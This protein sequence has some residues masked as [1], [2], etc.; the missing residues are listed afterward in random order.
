MKNIL[1]LILSTICFFGFGQTRFE[2]Y[3]Y[4]PCSKEVK[5]IKFFGLKKEG[6]ALSRQ[7][8]SGIL[9]LR[10][11]GV[12]VLSYVIDDIDSTQLGKKYHIKS[13][14]NFSDTLRLLSIKQCLEPI[15]HPNFVGYCCC[16]EK[17]EGKQVDY[18]QNGFKRIEGNFKKGKPVGELI[19]Y[20]PNGEI[21]EVHKYNKKSK[22]VK[23]SK[24][25]DNLF[26]KE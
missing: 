3:S 20:H 7:D 8:T 2:L 17:C 6:I 18:Y 4:D 9:L 21:S 14:K 1:T 24:P 25:K 23:K 16:D 22:L 5:A 19:F 26:F 13:V 11:T 12:Y 15:S 10:D